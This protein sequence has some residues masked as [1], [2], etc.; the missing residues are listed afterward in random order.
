MPKAGGK[1]RVMSSRKGEKS[2]GINKSFWLKILVGFLVVCFA[3][4]TVYALFFSPLL[5]VKFVTVDGAESLDSQKVIAVA[6]SIIQQKYFNTLDKA[7]LILL[8]TDEIKK[9][10]SE[11]FKIIEDVEISKKFPDKLVID[12][13][14]RKSSLV[15][16]SGDACF[17]IDRN[18]H[19]YA[20]A[21]FQ[22]NELGEQSLPVLRDLSQKDISMA[23]VSIEMGLANF[24][25][26]I[27]NKLNN[28]LSLNIK[29]EWS[30]PTLISGDLRVETT[31]GWQIYFNYDIGADKEIEMLK[32]VLNNS[33]DK[34]KRA[35]LEYIDLRLDNKVYYK[36]KTAPP[37]V[38]GDNN[39][40]APV[41][42]V[43]DTKKKK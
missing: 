9:A 41:V 16:C 5:V 19:A 28:E 42:K 4:V 1:G 34:D 22:S 36:L 23:T 24:M 32:T 8:N 25:E 14:E 33:I 7:N 26:N 13:K 15:F 17:V 38:E 10:L 40:V 21:D 12:I 37:V 3:G 35:D 2:N 43:D 27:K 6:N 29:Q 20:Q 30:T 18:G 39:V 11:K 31:E